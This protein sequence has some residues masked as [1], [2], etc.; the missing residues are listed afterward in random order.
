MRDDDKAFVAL[1]AAI[2]SIV[3]CV[4]VCSVY[5]DYNTTLVL[6]SQIEHGCPVEADR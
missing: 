3:L 1:L 5:F 2:A 6:L 4:S